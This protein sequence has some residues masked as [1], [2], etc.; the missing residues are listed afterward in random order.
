MFCPLPGYTQF[1]SW[2]AALRNL[3]LNPKVCMIYSRNSKS[4]ITFYFRRPSLITISHI[5]NLLR[6]FFIISEGMSSIVSKTII[7]DNFLARWHE[8]CCFQENSFRDT[9]STP[10][11]RAL[12]PVIWLDV[13]LSQEDPDTR[14]SRSSLCDYATHLPKNPPY[15]RHSTTSYQTDHEMTRRWR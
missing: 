8:L 5:T 11:F 1:R 6:S 14:A 3:L 7:Y 13:W 4:G 9:C 10:R 12:F 15:D 2:A